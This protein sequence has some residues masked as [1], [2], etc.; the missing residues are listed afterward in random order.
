LG[1]QTLRQWLQEQ[2][3]PYTGTW[4]ATAYSEKGQSIKH[5]TFCLKQRGDRIT[6]TISR[7]FPEEQNYRRWHLSA[8][9]IGNE[10][11]GS[12]WPTRRDITSYGSWCLK[13]DTDDR[14]VGYYLSWKH[15]SHDDLT[16]TEALKTTKC[17]LER[18]RTSGNYVDSTVRARKS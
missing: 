1:A 3:G 9:V 2:R 13:Q 10:L 7:T 4:Y 12:F 5:D 14:F 6:G 18:Y 8:T 17:T 15:E 11:Y 16:R